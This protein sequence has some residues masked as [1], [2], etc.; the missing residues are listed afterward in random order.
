MIRFVFIDRG[1]NLKV[2]GLTGTW[3][4]VGIE[5]PKFEA[6]KEDLAK[7]WQKLGGGGGGG[8]GRRL[9]RPWCFVHGV[10][11]SQSVAANVSNIS[12][13]RSKTGSM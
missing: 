2:L 7:I 4:A 12:F 6:K 11:R 9:H 3:G 5:M 13:E 10:R 8:G 1:V